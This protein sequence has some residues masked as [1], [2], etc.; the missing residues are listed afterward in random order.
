LFAR[1][2]LRAGL[3]ALAA[4]GF[5]AGAGSGCALRL[6]Y[7]EVP[8][9]DDNGVDATAAVGGDGGASP[10]AGAALA[11]RCGSFGL[12]TDGFDD[13]ATG[14]QWVPTAAAGVDLVETG[15]HLAIA[16]GAGAAVV[17]GRY[18]SKNAYDLRSSAVAVTVVR[19]AG[20]YS[21]L[22]VRDPEGRGAAIGV[23]GGTLV[24]LALERG[25]E[26]ERA[27]VGYDPARHRHWRLREASGVLHWETSADRATWSLLH[28]EPLPMSG[29]LAHGHLVARGQ[30][31]AGGE[32]WFDDVNLPAAPVPGPCSASGLRDTFDDG[33][34]SASYNNWADGTS[35]AG[36][37]VGGVL[38]LSFTGAGD[39]WCGVETRQI[40]D[41]RDNAVQVE[42]PTTVA[43]SRAMAFF[44]ALTPTGDKIKMGRSPDGMFTEMQQGTRQLA[45]QAVPYDPALHRFWRL[46]ESGGQTYWDTSADGA[47]WTN[48]MSAPTA[49]DLSA[50]IIDLAAGHWTPGPGTAFVVR[51]DQLGSAP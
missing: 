2:L 47:A 19:T 30:T 24:A 9:D 7:D 37:E 16:L 4:A 29:A 12:L 15:G 26:A 49:I 51:Y 17:E 41:L 13:G 32:T 8:A 27:Q 34:V 18:S 28:A 33:V 40:L 35:C 39:A 5:V 50:V 6:G 21:G 44:E 22:E 31:A 43:L 25:L 36:R 38:E 46:R 48:R 23:D 20:A 3:G 45:W 1:P 11:P 10:D 42:V 14:P